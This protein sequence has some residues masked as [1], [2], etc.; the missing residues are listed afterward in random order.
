MPNRLHKA[1][2][3]G[4]AWSWVAIMVLAGLS[5]LVLVVPG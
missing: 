4:G 3:W 2:Q 1:R 5:A